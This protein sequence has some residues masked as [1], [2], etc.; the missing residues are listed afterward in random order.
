MFFVFVICDCI[1]FLFNVYCVVLFMKGNCQQL[2]CGFFVVVINMFNELLSDYY[3]VNVLEDLE[4]C[5]GI[6]IY[7]EWFMILQLYVD[8]ELVGG[9]DIICQMYISGELYILFGV[10]LLDCILLEIII[11]DK[12]VEMICQGIVNVQ[13]VVIYLEIGLDYSVGFQLVLVG[14]Y[15]IVV[16]LNGLE[17]YFD[18]VS[19]QCV[20]GIVIDWV[21]MVQGE[22]FSLKFLGVQEIKLFIVWELQQCLVVGDIILID[23]CLVSGCVQVV[24]LVQVCVLEEEGYDVF[25]VLFKDIVFVFICYYGVFSCG[26]VECFVVYGFSNVYNVEGGMDVWVEQ[27]D[28]SVLCY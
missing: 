22:G 21:F 16:V 11:I 15:D 18:L 20:K 3:M 24:L 19:V 12:V 2:M 14:D 27:I 28:L 23:V 26:V 9:L 8:G 4:I 10:V 25:V 5:E 17:I 1:Q 13:G 7:G 6:K